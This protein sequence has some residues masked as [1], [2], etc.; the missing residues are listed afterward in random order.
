MCFPICHGINSWAI[1]Q[2]WRHGC[3]HN[4]MLSN[5]GIS[6]SFNTIEQLK[7]IISDDAIAHAVTLLTGAKLFFLIFDNINLYLHK[8]Q[9]WIH[10]TN[11]I[12]NITNAVV[13]SLSN[14]KPGFDDLK[15]TLDL[16]SKQANAT[17]E[18]ILP[19]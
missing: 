2:N 4:Q 7:S 16:H 18:D 19:T 12:L 10:N 14:V 11:T 5:S 6:V 8:S 3:A 1:L 15:S 17:I 9:Q 13:I